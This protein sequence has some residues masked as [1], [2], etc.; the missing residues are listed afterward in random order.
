MKY[1]NTSE[2]KAGDKIKRTRTKTPGGLVLGETYTIS[3]IIDHKRIMV[4]ET[5]KGPWHINYFETTNNKTQINDLNY[6]IY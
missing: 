6:D 5:N 4:E 1:T 3:K 2:V